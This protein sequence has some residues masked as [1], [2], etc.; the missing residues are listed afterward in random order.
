MAK[1]MDGYIYIYLSIYTLLVI[2]SQGSWFLF[3]KLREDFF[4]CFFFV[5]YFFIYINSWQITIAIL[6][7]FE[8]VSC[9]DKI[10]SIHKSLV[11][12]SLTFL[13]L[14]CSGIKW[15]FRQTFTSLSKGTV[16]GAFR[17]VLGHCKRG[18]ERER[19]RERDEQL[20]QRETEV[21]LQSVLDFLVLFDLCL[22]CLITFFVRISF[23]LMTLYRICH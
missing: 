12:F 18:R 20:I 1:L 6:K 8:F 4:F 3:Q 23:I 15:I 22:I 19:E 16:N 17:A 13:G 11:S 10:E 9:S 5:F 14:S 7:Y 2:D 21:P